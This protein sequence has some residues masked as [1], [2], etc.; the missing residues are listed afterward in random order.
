MMMIGNSFWQGRYHKASLGLF[1]V[2]ILALF[3]ALF[4]PASD[5]NAED[6]LHHELQVRLLPTE[7]SII[8]I[9]KV[10]LPAGSDTVEFTLRDGLT[11][12]ASGAELTTDLSREPTW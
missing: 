11:V 5:I 9:D 3:P 7:N 4:L 8:V 10:Q 2:L 6:I 1:L 12:T